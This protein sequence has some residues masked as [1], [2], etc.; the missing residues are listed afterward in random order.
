MD[1]AICKSI[2][3]IVGKEGY[4]TRTADLYTYGFDASIY[5]KTPD[6]VVQPRTTEQVSEILKIANAAKIPVVPRGAGTG[7]RCPSW[8]A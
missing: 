5:H 6:M 7:L 8:G 3:K 1:S 4:S 2:E